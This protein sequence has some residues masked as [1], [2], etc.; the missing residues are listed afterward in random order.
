MIFLIIFAAML[1]ND[2]MTLS[3]APS[4]LMQV[5]GGLDISKYIIFAMIIIIY[6]ILGCFIESIPMIIL[7]VPVVLPIL[8]KLGFDPIWFGT[9]IVLMVEA[10][11]ITPPVGMNVYIIAGSRKLPVSL[12]FRGSVPFVIAVMVEVVILTI[13]PVIATFLPNLMIK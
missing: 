3:R 8:M 13:Y 6:L 1:F 11:L 2:F 10:A 12:V 5:V 7:T 9:I 4:Q